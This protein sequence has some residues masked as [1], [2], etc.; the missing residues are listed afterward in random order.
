[1]LKKGHLRQCW[2]KQYLE[3]TAVR[4][5]LSG[6]YE[7]SCV[8][9]MLPLVGV[10]TVVGPL[11]YWLVAMIHHP[12]WQTA[13][14]REVDEKCAGRMPTLKDGPKLPILRATIKETMRWKPNVPTG[15]NL[16]TLL[17][18]LC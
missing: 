2:T 7:A 3:K 16:S 18:F 11:S 8:L 17:G 14:Q 5:V 15:W 6:D 1:M 9:G 10:F 12:E 4:P 13:V